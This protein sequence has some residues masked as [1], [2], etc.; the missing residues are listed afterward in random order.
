MD[1]TR[2]EIPYSVAVEVERFVL[3]EREDRLEISA[4]IH[5]EHD[6]QK[7]ILIGKRGSRIKE[8]GIAA[9][10][11]LERFFGKKVFLETFVRVQPRWSEDGR[12]LHRFG[13]E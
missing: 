8:I 3:M 12:S 13:Y 4:L 5:V 2:N 10:A 1:Q 11:E 9:R 6:S 7:G